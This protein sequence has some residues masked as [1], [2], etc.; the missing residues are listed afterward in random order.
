MRPVITAATSPNAT[1]TPAT[2]MTS[3]MLT[4]S[5]LSYWPR[6]TRSMVEPAQRSMS[7]TAMTSII[8]DNAATGISCSSG[9]P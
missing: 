4:I 9:A 3:A 8:A 2:R 6:R 7:P 1:V 5:S